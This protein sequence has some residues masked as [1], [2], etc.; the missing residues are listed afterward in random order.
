MQRAEFKVHSYNV[1]YRR[2]FPK[3]STWAM[4]FVIATPRDGWMW[5]KDSNK[6][7]IKK[8]IVDAK[9]MSDILDET[10]TISCGSFEINILSKTISSVPDEEK[11]PNPMVIDQKLSTVVDIPP[12]EDIPIVLDPTLTR[13]MRRHQI[14]AG[15]F[16]LGRLLN[17]KETRRGAILADD[18]GTGKT[19]VALSVMWALCRH[20]RAKSIVVCPLSLVRNWE[21]EIRKWLGPNLGRS[22]L[23]ISASNGSG[24]MVW[25][26]TV[27]SI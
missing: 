27:D 11:A 24:C 19:L 6:K 5:L 20:G 26:F 8:G 21:M 23:F 9:M 15:E 2:A 10:P 14:E 22:A 3:E 1:S 7:T 12:K 4:G 17:E 25:L 18:M 13:I 16:L